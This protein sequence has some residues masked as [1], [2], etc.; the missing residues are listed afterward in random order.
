VDYKFIKY[1][2]EQKCVISTTVSSRS[3]VSLNPQIKLDYSQH[4][5]KD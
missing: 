3:N 4:V 1:K 2:C 5:T